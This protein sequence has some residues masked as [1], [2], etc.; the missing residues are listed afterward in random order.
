MQKTPVSYV[1]PEDRRWYV[2]SASADTLGR[3]A[4]RIATVLRGKHKPS[5][6]PHT[7]NGDFVVVTEI[8][9][10]RVTGKKLRQ[11]IYYHHTGYPGHL[12][13]EE[14]R[15]LMARRPE[16]VIRRAVR[17]MLPHNRLGDRMIKR[18]RLYQGAEHPHVA[19]QPTPLP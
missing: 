16:E 6:S 10:I 18:L 4:A 3:V 2:V 7:D 13:A 5:F 1:R 19:Q 8:E 17:G 15:H 9:R 14:L 11:K 12:K